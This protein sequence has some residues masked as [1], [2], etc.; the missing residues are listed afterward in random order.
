M[1]NVSR[2]HGVTAA[3][4]YLWMS[5]PPREKHFVRAWREH[6]GLSLRKFA[7]LLESAPGVPLMSH[8]N[9]GRIET[10]EQPYTQ[11]FLEAAAR[12]LKVSPVTL[13]TVDPAKDGEVVDLVRAIQERNDETAMSV[14]RTLAGRS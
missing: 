2:D 10:G 6:R 12:A 4:Y 8:A 13:L 3:R 14:L 5:P 9:I 1:C 11:D 7:D